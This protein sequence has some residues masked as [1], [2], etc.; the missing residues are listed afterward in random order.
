MEIKGKNGFEKYQEV[1]ST[2]GIAAFGC[3]AEAPSRKVAYC[4]TDNSLTPTAF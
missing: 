1:E 3:S 4:R 2:G